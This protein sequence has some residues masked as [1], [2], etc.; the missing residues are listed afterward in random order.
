M[1]E[2]PILFS[3]DMVEAILDGRKTMT[4]RIFKP[5]KQETYDLPGDN[6]LY[7]RERFEVETDGYV[8]F[9]ANNR[10]VKHN[11]AY[12]ELTKW[13]P[14]IHM[15][16]KDARI[17]LQ[18][19]EV[20]VERLQDISEEDAISEGIVYDDF[21]GKYKCPLCQFEGHYLSN[22]TFLCDDGFYSTAKKAFAEL[23]SSINGKESW[24]KNPYV[25]VITFEVLSTTGKPS[26]P[27]HF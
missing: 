2:K 12:R 23:W 22:T 24:Y 14:S 8:K 27:A 6:I 15:P 19:K 18:E 9:Y 1:K 17:W 5:N 11:T 25:L 21:F 20:R 10:E 13:K 4:R 16:K 3:T 7:V 26:A